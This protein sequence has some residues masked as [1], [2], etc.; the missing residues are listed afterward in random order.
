MRPTRKL[1]DLAALRGNY[2]LARELHG[3]R[4]L[5]VVK[6]DAYGHGAVRCAQAL[7]SVAD[8]FAVA[9]LDE[10]IE[11]RE[12]GIRDPILILEGVFSGAELQ[13]ALAHGLWLVVHHDEQVRMLEQGGGA[14]G[15]A[16]VWLKIDS[17]M[18][19]AG[20]APEEAVRIHGRLLRSGRALAITLMTHFACADELDNPMTVEQIANFE[21]A[22]DMLPGPRS[23]CNSAGLLHWP[24][25]HR[26]WARPGLMIYGAAP[27]GRNVPGLQPVMTLQSRIIAERTLE[28]GQSL[29]YGADYTAPAR[30]RVGLVCAGYADGYPQ[31]APTGTPVV[32]DGQ[33]TRLLGRVSMD[34]LTVDLSGLPDAG[35][36]SAV[37]LWGPD[38]RVEQVA[39]AAGRI[40]YELLCHVNRPQERCQDPR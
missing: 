22:T 7:A 13:L 8:G 35:V 5:A 23:L 33:R 12:A 31:N 38:V 18:S 17:G 15:G 25:A 14:A 26:D 24:A 34:M 37:Q 28:P 3:A 36:G 21:R 27:G 6:A 30:H 10:A 20:F 16:H 32:V 2:R 39:A 40:A 29:G 4:A 1:I 19:R 9:F 11:L